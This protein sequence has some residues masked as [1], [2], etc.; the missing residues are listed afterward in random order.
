MFNDEM[1]ASMKRGSYLINTARGD[2]REC[3]IMAAQPFPFSARY[4]LR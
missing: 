4:G 1:F 2:S 3:G